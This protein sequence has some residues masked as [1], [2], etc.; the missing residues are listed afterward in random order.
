MAAVTKGSGKYFHE[1]DR[2]WEEARQTGVDPFIVGNFGGRIPVPKDLTPDYVRD[3]CRGR[4]LQ[5]VQANRVGCYDV[6]FTFSKSVSVALFG[7]TPH[8]LW[9][10]RSTKLLVDATRPEVERLVSD[11][12]ANS[13][14]KGARKVESKG[15]AFGF[16]HWESSRKVVHGHVHY[17]IPNVTSPEKGSPKSIA[18]VR[19]QMY[20]AQGL[21]RARANKRLDDMLQDRGFKTVREGK[22][23]AVAGVPKKLVEELSPSRRAM[24][25]AMKKM[26]FT[27]PK[28]QEF[29]ARHAR[30]EAGPRTL[31]DPAEFNK[32]CWKL[33]ERH[34]LK[35][36]ADLKRPAA[37][38]ARHRDPYQAAS[39]AHDVAASAR[40]WLSKKHG[41]FTKEQFL[42]RVFTRGIGRDTTFEALDAYA[43]AALKN[44]KFLGIQKEV[45]PDGRIL[46]STPQGKTA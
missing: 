41:A 6:T 33:A 4:P 26:G 3:L 24:N 15:A 7:L 29:Y 43:N 32:T 28:A 31:G 25:Q 11:Q 22:A 21:M 27:T 5:R 17:A 13:G 40:D 2:V 10:D 20:E 30:G 45:Q 39:T 34:G 46:Y 19:E 42:E 14:A 12:R 38:P 1:N 23:V 16:V 18:K 9:A 36:F 44:S 8:H 35:G 37:D